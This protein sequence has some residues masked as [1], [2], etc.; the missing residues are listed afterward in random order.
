[1]K[2][3]HRSKEYPKDRN[4]YPVKLEEPKETVTSIPLPEPEV[5]PINSA[6]PSS[7]VFQD[8]M[9]DLENK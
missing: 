2:T 5:I 4:K 6:S 3:K 7:P 9:V 1:M 8:E